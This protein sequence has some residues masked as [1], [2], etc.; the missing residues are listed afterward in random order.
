MPTKMGLLMVLTIFTSAGGCNF[1]ESKR[2][3]NGLEDFVA[4]EVVE[5]RKSGSWQCN[6]CN[7]QESTG[8]NLG[9]FKSDFGVEDVVCRNS[10]CDE[11]G[12]AQSGNAYG[13]T[14]IVSLGSSCESF[15]AAVL[16]IFQYN[17][18]CDGGTVTTTG[19]TTGTVTTTVRLK[20]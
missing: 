11:S 16:G 18:Y 17:Y 15:C 4:A 1:H 8:P 6:G 14:N 19:T 20:V 2:Y 7:V 5:A 3:Q 12:A 13:T 9:G 10:D